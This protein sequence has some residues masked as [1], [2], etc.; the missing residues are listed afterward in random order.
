MRSRIGERAAWGETEHLL[1]STID[2]INHQT[3]LLAMIYRDREK[4]EPKHP[5][6]VPR[7]GQTR[8]EKPAKTGKTVGLRE[9]ARM[10][11][12][13]TRVTHRKGGDR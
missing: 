7:P 1:A 3:W 10:M 9:L 8:P 13:G 12:G 4:P 2:T 11:G 6:P 5:D